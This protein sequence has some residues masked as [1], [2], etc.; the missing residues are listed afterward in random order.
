LHPPG[1]LKMILRSWEGTKLQ[2]F[3]L[4]MTQ[5]EFVQWQQYLSNRIPLTAKDRP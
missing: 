1:T 5:Q 3:Y 2:V 4:K